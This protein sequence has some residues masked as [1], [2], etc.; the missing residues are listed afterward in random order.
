MT[1]RCALLIS[2][3]RVQSECPVLTVRQQVAFKRD[4]GVP[5]AAPTKP[6]AALHTPEFNSVSPGTVAGS[7][8]TIQ[9]NG[10]KTFPYRVS[11]HK[12]NNVCVWG[13]QLL[14]VLR[15]Y[16]SVAL[17]K[18]TANFNKVSRVMQWSLL[19]EQK[20]SKRRVCR[21]RRSS[22]HTTHAIADAGSEVSYCGQFAN[23]STQRKSR[24]SL[25][26]SLTYNVAQLT[27][28]SDNT[29]F[30]TKITKR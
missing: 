10:G 11:L 26:C 28:M 16:I 9:Q 17:Q 3:G 6:A 12:N 8:T 19:T 21:R 2:L 18:K 27:K 14:P 15:V 13:G 23:N 22:C 1:G 30:G 24:K 5:Q 7:H 29:P 20:E 25:A 4:D